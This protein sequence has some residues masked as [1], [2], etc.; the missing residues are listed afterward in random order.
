M[1]ATLTGMTT[2]LI[3]NATNPYLEKFDCLWTVFLPLAVVNVSLLKENSR[4]LPQTAN[5]SRRV[6]AVSGGSDVR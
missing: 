2:F 6:A 5:G 4:L 1:V 3:A